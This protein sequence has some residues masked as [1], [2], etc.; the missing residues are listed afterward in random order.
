MRAQDM[1]ALS[2]EAGS[3]R[4]RRVTFDWER[5]PLH[6]IPGDAYGTHLINVLHMLL[7]AG[8]RWFVRVY[9]EALP[10]VTDPGLRE[11]MRGFMGQ[12]AVHAAAHQAYLERLR[13]QGI[14]PSGFV[15]WVEWLL[16]GVFD[17]RL[18]PPP[19]RR[20]WLEVRL[21]GIAAIEQLT[22]ALA[23]WI[24]DARALDAAGADPTML[25]CLRWHGAEEIEHRA[26]AQETLEHIAASPYRRRLEGTLIV[27]PLISVLWHQGTR[28]LARRDPA[29]PGWGFGR[30]LARVRA[31]RA[32]GKELLAAIGR[33]L[34]PGHDPAREARL[35]D[36]QAYLAR[37]PAVAALS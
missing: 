30:Y 1:D 6:W 23:S 13:A 20:A 4:P 34:R 2:R 28:Y 25:D 3:I 22:C 29:R 12:E 8:E 18:A 27:V 10:L 32:P 26:V 11:R 14:D 35:E 19:L 37:S 7:P 21:A 16:D 17:A 31:G 24:L 36:A 33:S 15:A 9:K 5:T